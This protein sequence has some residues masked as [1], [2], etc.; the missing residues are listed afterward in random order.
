MSSEQKELVEEQFG[1]P[2]GG[3][4]TILLVEE[5]PALRELASIVLS[6]YGYKV[7][8][9][10]SGTE[11]LKIWELHGSTVDL[12]LTDMLIPEGMTGLDLSARLCQE[13][14]GL[15][16]VYTSGDS[17]ELAAALP[18]LSKDTHF[19]PKPYLPAALI[20]IIRETLAPASRAK[21][22]HPVRA[23]V[24]REA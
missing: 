24:K 18:G 10:G 6:R 19:L 15:K 4:E 7:L 5:E 1:Q 13:R 21:A 17:A 11:A 9:A 8:H 23:D 16:V 14:P 20:R 3:H 12:L 22:Q 2:P